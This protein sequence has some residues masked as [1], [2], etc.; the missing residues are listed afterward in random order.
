MIYYYL[1]NINILRVF[2]K[3][4]GKIEKILV[5]SLI[6]LKKQNRLKGREKIID[7]ILPATEGHGRKIKTREGNSLI[8]FASNSYLGLSQDSRLVEAEHRSSQRFGVGPGAVRFISGTYSPHVKLENGIASFFKKQAAMIFNSA[9]SANCGLIAPLMDE[10]TII[11]SD[12]LNHNSIIMA[13]RLAG[14][15]RDKKK[16]YK[17]CDVKELEDSVRSSIG[18]AKRLIVVT[19]GVFSMRGDHAPL[20]D[21]LD[22]SKKYDPH[23]QEGIITVVDDSHGIGALGDTGRGTVEICD[24]HDIDVITGTLGKALGVDGGFVV[25]SQKIIEFLR[26]TSPFYIYSNPVSPGVASA[27]IQALEILDS[28]EGLEI[29]NRLKENTEFF[30]RGIKKIGFKT[31]KGI[32]PIIPLVI[33]NSKEAKEIVARL[34]RKGIWVTA[35]TYPVVPRG[36]DTI[37]VQICAAHTIKDL[38]FALDCFSVVRN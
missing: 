38:E 19:D 13:I 36:Q 31:V 34:Y 4:L 24:A 37:R 5:D 30:R 3:M 6:S 33:G 28:K 32:H 7:G 17:H 2:K 9:Y 35:L 8:N 15:G 18:E 11:I 22:I 26:E 27:S 16:I 10:S 25:S 21:I 20:A 1:R 23:F 29:L 12:E 14:A